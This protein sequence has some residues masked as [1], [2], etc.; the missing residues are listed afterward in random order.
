[1]TIRVTVL[2]PPR[3]SVDGTELVDLPAQR[4]RFALLVFLAIER[5]AARDD[6]A[7]L[8]WADSDDDRARHALSQSL[9]ELKKYLGDG[10]VTSQSGRLIVAESLQTDAA[11]FSEKLSRN[12]VDDALAL[13]RGAFL[14]GYILSNSVAFEQWLDRQRAHYER[15]HRKARRDQLANLLA[16]DRLDDAREAARHWVDCDPLED[17]ANHKLIELLARCGSRS[18]ALSV[19]ATYEERLRQEL[20]ISPLDDTKELVRR[21][22]ANAGQSGELGTSYASPTRKVTAE[23][24]P[25][26]EHVV[27][28]P[29]PARPRVWLRRSGIGLGAVITLLAL[30]V[31]VWSILTE[32]NIRIAPHWNR[33]ESSAV[34]LDPWRVVV[35]PFEYDPAVSQRINEENLLQDAL[36]RW[37]DITLVDAF[38]VQD[39]LTQI[40]GRLRPADARRI[41]AGLGAGRFVLGQISSMGD[42]LRVHAVLFDA[43]RHG[44]RIDDETVRVHKSLANVETIFSRLADNLVFGHVAGSK[45]SESPASTRSAPARRA[46]Y[47]AME[48]IQQW[49]LEAADSNLLS[50]VRFDPDYATA[51]LWLAQVRAWQTRP[52]MEWRYAVENAMAAHDRLAPRD[53]IIARAL[54]ERARGQFVEACALYRGLTENAPRDFAA[55][56]GLA[57]CL[58][59]DNAVLSDSASPTGFSFRTSLREATAS[60]ERAFVLMPSVYRAFRADGFH[61]VRWLFFTGAAP[62][63]GGRGPPGDTS[64]FFAY[65]SWNADTLAFYPRPIEQIGGANAW[66]RARGLDR[67]VK[68]QRTTFLGLTKAW[69]SAFPKDAEAKHAVAIALELLGDPAA[70]DTLRGARALADS[71]VESLRLAASEVWMSLKFSVPYNLA[72][73]RRAA[74]LADSIL[75]DSL[76]RSM[77]EPAVL[78]GLAALRGKV[79][80]AADFYRQA[81]TADI[82]KLA[83]ARASDAHGLLVYAVFGG[84]RDSLRILDERLSALADQDLGDERA[85]YSIAQRTQVTA[86]NDYRLTLVGVPLDYDLLKVQHAA[87][88]GNRQTVDLWVR[89]T[90]RKRAGIP[91][92]DL[93][94]DILLPEARMI[95]NVYGASTAATWIDPHLKSLRWT[96]PRVLADLPRS[97]SLV[98]S[99][100]FRAD[101]AAE[102]GD[103]KSARDWAGP[104]AVLWNDADDFLQ[105]DVSRMN[106]LARRRMPK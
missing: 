72:G 24:S 83:P 17:E 34:V 32:G 1:V 98:R 63:R 25:V 14:S 85:W 51:S 104:V 82:S 81:Q 4:T 46:Y 80:Q 30:V 70:L 10:W 49:D 74:I 93:T 71:R 45:S 106:S 39:A 92:K 86:F 58:N 56:F 87:A 18:E 79:G 53:Q 84:P 65:P 15:I 77:V 88:A 54:A 57:D 43:S 3:C 47:T 89:D 91:A 26:V 52:S 69:R 78:A 97:A 12:R 40:V 95:R 62:L 42:S 48:A 13:Y 6:V 9:Y 7:A 67:A 36:S 8:F 28:Q 64:V 11:E 16:S 33:E 101:V 38:Q 102:L 60:Y 59:R 23:T 99:F 76:A 35:F 2:G 37:T 5:N 21:I 44:E 55:W 61:T 103:W 105:G 68:E 19:Y 94:I 27:E 90:M 29:G 75:A 96:T 73:V 50:A 20:D 31:D 22:R 66:A 100:V 41:A